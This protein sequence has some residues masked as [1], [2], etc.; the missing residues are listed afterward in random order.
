MYWVTRHGVHLDRVAASW[1]I[2]RFADKSAEFG[3]L[4]PDQPGPPGSTGFSLAGT[5]FPPHDG[6]LS[7]FRHLVSAY[8]DGDLALETMARSIELAIQLILDPRGDHDSADGLT[9]GLAVALAVCSEGM[10]A[11]GLDDAETL[12]RSFPFYDSMYAGLVIGREVGEGILPVDVAR[13]I[14][15][16]RSSPARWAEFI[17]LLGNKLQAAHVGRTSSGEDSRCTTFSFA[18]GP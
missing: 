2:A 12:R 16:L 5:R 1:F 13:R 4:A 11:L 7:T 15:Q 9:A 3:F 14:P 10:S 17:G 8:K 18:V 6:R